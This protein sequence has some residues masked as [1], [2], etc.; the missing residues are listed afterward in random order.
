LAGVQVQSEYRAAEEKYDFAA[1]ATDTSD[2]KSR[3][4]VPGRKAEKNL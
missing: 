3:C 2:S 4:W 1:Y